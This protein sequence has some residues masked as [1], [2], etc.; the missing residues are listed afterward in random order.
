ML[1][2]HCGRR[3]SSQKLSPRRPTYS[4]LS[5][6]HRSTIRRVDRQP[7]VSMS[8]SEDTSQRLCGVQVKNGHELADVQ[9]TISKNAQTTATAIGPSATTTKETIVENGRPRVSSNC[10]QVTVLTTIG[11]ANEGNN[12]LAG[13]CVNECLIMAQRPLRAVALSEFNII[14][15]IIR[16]LWE[17]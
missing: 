2:K 11:K 9:L 3:W 6:C 1:S 5:K 16:I 7:S 14:I 13:A 17:K 8:V 15:I 12:N 4:S 10:S